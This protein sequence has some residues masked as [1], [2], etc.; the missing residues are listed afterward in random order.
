MPL[1]EAL[2]WGFPNPSTPFGSAVYY[3]IRFSPA[4]ERLRNALLYAWHDTVRQIADC[5]SDPGVARLKLDWWREE[6]SRMAT[7][8]AQHPLALRLQELALDRQAL[9]S[10]HALL[11][12]A[13]AAV[14]LP[15][16]ADDRQF[17]AACRARLGEFFVLLA[18]AGG[19][20]RDGSRESGA[21]CEAIDRI[22]RL[23]SAPHGAPSELVEALRHSAS[24]A[25]RTTRV[26]ALLDQFE[27]PTGSTR[28]QLTPFA[29]RL[30]ALAEAMH[31]KL[32][33]K[34]YPVDET[35]IDRPPI[36]NLW[37]AWR[38]R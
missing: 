30:L 15:Q 12:A 6:V 16:P 7:G 10:M 37:T 31:E 8:T 25:S 13:E 19:Q 22:R 3:A 4:E 11:Q 29:R 36:A 32:R 17:A 27:V 1:P 14:L 26:D 34:G 2:E 23:H 24:V 9:E 28:A 20:P 35:A 38:C 33:R 5:P 21:Y 18:T